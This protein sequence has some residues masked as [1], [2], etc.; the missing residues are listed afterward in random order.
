MAEVV[1]GEKAEIPA[2]KEE[3][4]YFGTVSTMVSD[5]YSHVFLTKYFINLT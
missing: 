2:Q 3:K 1:E 5:S 4:I